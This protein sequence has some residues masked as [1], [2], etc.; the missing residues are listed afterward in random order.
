MATRAITL[1]LSV[2][3]ADTVRRELEKIGPAGE[4]AIRRL[5]AAAQKAATGNGGLRGVSGAANELQSSLANLASRAGPVGSA[6]SG[7]GGAG[8]AAAA[9]LGALTLGLSQVARAGDEMVANLSR[10]RVATGSIESARQV[11]EQLYQ[12]S[13]QTGQA[14]A[15]SAG[16]F[17]RYSIAAR[18]IGATNDEVVRL[19]SGVQRAATLMGATAQEASGA[20]IQLGQ[21]LASG[22]LQGEELRSLME[23]LPNLAEQLAKELGVGMGELR[24]MGSEG[25]LTAD[26]V[27]PA[28]LRASQ[29]L[30]AEY[31]KMPVTMSRAFDQLQVASQGFLARLDEALGL[32]QGIARALGSAAQALNGLRDRIPTEASRA[33]DRTEQLNTEIK[34]LRDRIALL[35]PSGE[36]EVRATPRRGG[37]SSQLQVIGAN[38]AGDDMLA[39]LR[40][41]LAER[42]RELQRHAQRQIDIATDGYIRENE[43]AVAA[44]ERAAQ[45]RRE[46]SQKEIEELRTQ[47]DQRYKVQQEYQARVE[48]INRARANNAITAVDAEKL[49][50]QAADQRDEAL[51]RA[52]GTQRETRNEE[53]ELISDLVKEQGKLIE[54]TERE[55]Q[56]A[57]ERSQEVTKGYEDNLAVIQRETELVGASV[58]QREVELAILRETQRLKKEQIEPDSEEG[59]RRLDLV[60]QIAKG[61]VALRQQRDSIEELGRIGENVFDRLGDSMV[62][63]FI[64]GE[65]K[66]VNF[67]NVLRGIAASALA[68][69]AKLALWNPIRNSLF[70]A[71]A[72]TL[73]SA[74]GGGGSKSGGTDL[75]SLVSSGR[76]VFS[77]WG[78]GS[79]SSGLDAWGAANLGFLGFSA[80]TMANFANPASLAAT[81][82]SELYAALPALPGATAAPVALP[83]LMNGGSLLGGFSSLSN[84]LGI[85][86][87]ALPGLMSGNYA[88]AGMGVGGAALGTMILP[89]IGTI[90][91]GTLGNLVGGLFGGGKTANPASSV[92][93][94]VD[95]NGQLTVLGSKSKHMS[96]EEGLAQTKQAL[97]GLNAAIS[98]R[99]LSLTS[100]NGEVVANTYQG[101][102]AWR[103]EDA[104]RSMT[105]AILERLTGGSESVM[106]VVANEIAK[107]AE[108]NLDTAFGNIDWVRTVYEP[109]SSTKEA[110]GTLQ[111]ALDALNKTFGDA[112]TKAKELGLSTT[113]L[114]ANLAKAAEAART[115]VRSQYW[116]LSRTAEGRGYV[117]DVEGVRNF[118]RA[119]FDNFT[120]AGV[121]ADALYQSQLRNVLSQL[122]GE[123]LTDVMNSFRGVDDAA[124]NVAA[125]LLRLGQTADAAATAQERRAAEQEAAGAIS[126]L[127]DYARSL[128]YGE[129]STLSARQ[130]YEAATSQ[131]NAVAGAAVA[132][133]ANSI[134]R[135]QE[136]AD[137]YLATSRSIN[138]SGSAY[139]Q[140]RDR[141][142]ALLGQIGESSP[143]N[144]AET[145][146]K[147]QQEQ[148]V[149]LVDELRTLRDEVT[150]LRQEQQQANARGR[151][152]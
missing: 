143:E 150:R 99:G 135:F 13:L 71:N 141:V 69:F 43:E 16:Q 76:S 14:V 37:I 64:R 48:R 103:N 21:A 111:Q 149:A 78:N 60:T 98:G 70:G 119:N 82:T 56:A 131:F 59:R 133:D 83:G 116:Q 142:L 45:G 125:E 33:N 31:E 5:D 63:A 20:S 72:G 50:Q 95:D 121:D 115:E 117:N 96:A 15:D 57:W 146:R 94:G 122:T 91:G 108:A 151:A 105:Q 40:E 93:I 123:Q 17:A 90:V 28:L 144:L 152:A 19:V 67:G 49:L 77:A 139:A 118:Y 18:Q 27:F 101:K 26:R 51:K 52:A 126:S 87:A 147:G 92:Q 113:D 25:E 73:S 46:R 61:N 129:G 88:Q 29:N 47:I 58:E 84:V 107:G 74:F 6:L 34:S 3:D 138:G 136:F 22:V 2:R 23:N 81:T 89:G 41:Q 9:G 68:D 106:A 148:T 39:N 112:D 134:R 130:Q 36:T 85:A 79:I 86:G 8:L 127:S 114:S 4:E 24:K 62:D 124:S 100:T 102:D 44:G 75:L 137:Q 65:G 55:R 42:E 110:S 11:Y 53:M 140:D 120:K 104:Q 97:D 54:Q 128:S 32:S 80:P 35:A 132:G 66:A 109:L 7:L 10:I 1:S 145:F 38:N 12:I 30:N